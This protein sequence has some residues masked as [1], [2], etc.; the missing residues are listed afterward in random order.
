LEEEL[1]PAPQ[2]A[3]P[4]TDGGVRAPSG[5]VIEMLQNGGYE[6]GDPATSYKLP[7]HWTGVNLLTPDRLRCNTPT[8][9]FSQSGECAFRFNVTNSN[10]NR[11][12]A[13]VATFYG[14]STGG[15]IDISVAVK[16]TDITGGVVSVKFGFLDGEIQKDKIQLPLGTYDYQT[17][18]KTYWMPK[19]LAWIRVAVGPNGY[20]SLLVDNASL[21]FTPPGPVVVDDTY[22][23][24][25]NESLTT[26]LTNGLF[27]N[28]TLNGATLQS[29]TQPASGTVT[30]NADGTFTY[31]PSSPTFTG[32]ETFTYTV[33]ST[34]GSATGTA[35]ILV[36]PNAPDAV[37]D[38]YPDVIINTPFSQPAAGVLTNDIV[39]GA[40]LS[41]SSTTGTAGGTLNLSADGSFTY[42]PP[43]NF[44]TSGPSGDDTFTYT[45]SNVT[46]FDSATITFT[47]NA[48]PVAVDD[49]YDVYRDVTGVYASS[50][51]VIANDALN[52]GAVTTGVIPTTLGGSVNMLADGTFTYALAPTAGLTQMNVDS[53]TYEISN[54]YASDTATVTLNVYPM[55]PVALDDDYDDVV[56]NTPYSVPATGVLTNDTPH[57]GVLA[58]LDTTGSQGGTLSL[59]ADGSFTYTP[60]VDFP[61]GVASDTETFAYTL[62]NITGSDGAT[63]TFTVNRVPVAVDD[64]YDVYRDASGL[65]TSASS[66][67]VNDTLN[68]ATVTAV[69]IPT[70]LG[71]SVI[72]DASGNFTYALAPTAGLT[73]VDV[74]SFSYTL[75][76]AF[77]S[78]SAT[79]TLNVYPM[80]PLAVDDDY[81]DVVINTPY[82]VPAAGVLSNDTP[83]G[84]TLSLLSTT[85]SQGG[86]LSLSADGSFT[87]TPPVDFPSSGLSAQETFSYTLTNITGSDG[88]TITFTVNAIPIA[89][90]DEYD[91]YRDASGIYTSASSVTVND[92]LNGGTVT[93]ATIPTTLGGSVTIDASGNFT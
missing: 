56:I 21:L 36:N 34:A 17:L 3:F 86:T 12:I 83:R 92:T 23:I 76:S 71:G 49:T 27:A 2:P 22:T 45:L 20:G 40:T 18:T 6:I 60:P 16:G 93:A 44:P 52:G 37:D 67:T 42:T 90:N 78:D 39:E 69:T 66:V 55:I 32:A 68:G 9:T 73:Q 82:S 11:R 77:G 91:V 43:A 87:Y 14:P 65:Y 61:V 8:L 75:S 59:S 31:T 51:S 19:T 57:G 80:T 30:V 41:L 7:L 35:T 85:G 28:D 4:Q 79:V 15:R 84:G 88:A 62:T 1:T 5:L 74:D 50:G 25:R 29:F 63:I 47:V 54:A 33:A 26:T 89:V 58:L 24:L 38:T 70:T 64:E 13:S 81:D 46:G 53:F 10:V 72:I 48:V